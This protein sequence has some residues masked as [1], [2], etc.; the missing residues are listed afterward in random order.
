ME[1]I[2]GRMPLHLAATSGNQDVVREL[3]QAGADV[4]ERDANGDTPLLRAVADGDSPE[5][6]KCLIEAGSDIKVKCN[7][8][9]TALCQALLK[10]VLRNAEIITVENSSEHIEV[11]KTDVEIFQLLLRFGADVREKDNEGRTLLHIA[12]MLP[13]EEIFNSLIDAGAIE[14]IEEKNDA[15]N[16]PLHVAV[17][18]KNRLIVKRL[19]R[20][21]AD[22][23]VKNNLDLTPFNYAF[24][25]FCN[26]LTRDEKYQSLTEAEVEA[27]VAVEYMNDTQEVAAEKEIF[28]LFREHIS[29]IE[30]N[31]A[32]QLPRF[33]SAA[34]SALKRLLFLVL[35]FLRRFI[36]VN[37]I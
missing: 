22:F 3:I 13:S 25:N 11:R 18:F 33:V 27:L 36:Y 23:N 20:N 1:A 31:E 21:G 32:L 16:T 9:F 30:M 2:N 12:A 14:S 19:L 29:K 34:A 10:P 28:S 24:F 6:V 5:I 17:Q 15:G 8:G 35:P 4:N 26:L 37:H 7:C